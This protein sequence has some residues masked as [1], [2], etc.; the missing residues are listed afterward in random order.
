MKKTKK[1]KRKKMTTKKKP[2]KKKKKKPSTAS[3]P[4]QSQYNSRCRAATHTSRVISRDGIH[5][6]IT[7]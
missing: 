2:E 5:T 4:K 6:A 7:L 3:I 1:K